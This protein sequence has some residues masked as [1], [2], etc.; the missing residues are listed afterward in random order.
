[1]R[2]TIQDYIG[3]NNGNVA[4]FSGNICWWQIRFEGDGQGNDDRTMICYKDFDEDREAN[5]L[6]PDDHITI[7][8]FEKIIN[9]PE[10]LMTGVSY[11]FGTALWNTYNASYKVRLE[12]HWLLKE[13]ELPY[14]YEFGELL[15]DKFET[16]SAD[17]S[18]YDRKFP[19]PTGKLA[20]DSDEF[21][22]PKDLMILATAD[23][24]NLEEA[25]HPNG[26]WCG[27]NYHSGWGTIGIYRKRNGGFVFHAGHINWA[28]D[29]LIGKWN[30]FSQITKNVLEILGNDFVAQQFLL[31]NPDFE[32]QLLEWTSSGG[33]T[34]T[35][36]TPGYQ[37]NKCVFINSSDSGDTFIYQQ[38]IPV[39]TRRNYR[40]T[41]FAKPGIPQ[42]SLASSI[43]IHLE[44][45]DI[46]KKP[47]EE[48]ITAQYPSN[49]NGWL[50]I[51]DEGSIPYTDQEDIMFQVRVKLFVKSGSSA[52]FD[53]VKVEEL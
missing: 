24:V 1:M 10:N 35:V 16:D 32:N 26:Y 52:Y 45:I 19:I 25:L 46:F 28:K 38:Y 14:G 7:N 13:T 18:D 43:S 15:F 41:C 30:H 50:E 2:N 42:D 36:T 22:A 27:P 37:S 12:K 5:P 3:Q 47:I 34:I 53:N 17:F 31:V 48:F 21:T 51:S 6:I 23:L 29:G 33:G 40:I 8:W 9:R 4:F 39:R 49:N 44:T 11:Y 20:N